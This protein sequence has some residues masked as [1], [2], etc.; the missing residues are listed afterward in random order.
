MF[1]FRMGLFIWPPAIWM[2]TWT[3]VA[4]ASAFEE[5]Q[6]D[7][8]IKIVSMDKVAPAAVAPAQGA[9]PAAAGGQLLKTAGEKKSRPVGRMKGKAARPRVS[10]L[11]PERPSLLPGAVK[12]EKGP[13]KRVVV[14]RP[15]MQ[16]CDQCNVSIPARDFESGAARS[17]NG[18]LYCKECAR[19]LEA[20]GGALGDVWGAGLEDDD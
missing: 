19:K 14:R 11:R 15:R 8:D 1:T 4:P 17:W 18:Q 9:R 2:P 13:E 5:S 3:P 16:F 6:T 20:Q 10:E 12:Q 7:D